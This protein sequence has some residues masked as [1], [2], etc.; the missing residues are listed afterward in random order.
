MMEQRWASNLPF[1]FSTH[2]AQIVWRPLHVLIL[3]PSFRPMPTHV[4]D[5]VLTM[6]VRSW[7]DLRWQGPCEVSSFDANVNNDALGLGV[8]AHHVGML[9]LK[10]DTSMDKKNMCSALNPESLR[11]RC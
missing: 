1:T 2:F 3:D 6:V 5:V 10:K 8:A 9:V 11:L 4:Q 7:C